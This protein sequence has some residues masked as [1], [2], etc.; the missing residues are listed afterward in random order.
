MGHN[1]LLWFFSAFQ[2][3][4]WT[5]FYMRHNFCVGLYF[6]TFSALCPCVEWTFI[7]LSLTQFLPWSLHS[8]ERLVSGQSVAAK[9]HLPCR[10]FAQSFFSIL[11][12]HPHD[13]HGKCMIFS[14]VSLHSCINLIPILSGWTIWP[15]SCFWCAFL[16]HGTT[17]QA[18]APLPHTHLCL[19]PFPSGDLCET[20]LGSWAP[21]CSNWLRY[22][23]VADLELHWFSSGL[24]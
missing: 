6:Y 1:E 7:L 18:P 5:S 16:L 21:N 24:E 14:L 2:L 12:Y 3:C 20:P 4:S 13:A 23:P 17:K 15:L 10:Y 8:K 22:G 11:Y 9:M 19:S